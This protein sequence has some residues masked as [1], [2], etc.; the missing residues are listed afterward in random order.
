MHKYSTIK[1]IFFDYG[2]TLDSNGI[3]WKARFVP[4][5]VKYG[6]QVEQPIFDAAF[7]KSDDSLCEEG[8]PNLTLKQIL[9]EQV[10]RVLVNLDCYKEEIKNKIANEFY[11]DSIK[12]IEKNKGI[13]QY[14]RKKFKT[15]IISNNYGNLHAI[16]NET[17]LTPLMD[18]IVDSTQVSSV[19]PDAKIFMS[20]INSIQ[21][22]P[23][24]AIMIGDSL[25]RDML[26]AKALGMKHIYIATP[27]SQKNYPCSSADYTISNL[28]EL[29]KYIKI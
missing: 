26:G 22:I 5:Y 28:N 8:N 11:N 27:E 21:I 3:P 1:A 15:G 13:I 16:C 24:E 17:G 9:H 23:Q 25:K 19:K 12:Q 6:I 14:L 20:A 2:G 10:K 4:L 18:V 7:Y 29:R